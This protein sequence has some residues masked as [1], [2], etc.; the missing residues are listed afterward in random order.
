MK[1][2]SLARPLG[3]LLALAL[4]AGVWGCQTWVPSSD[5]PSGKYLDHPPQNLS[6]LPPLP[7]PRE[8]AKLEQA[9]EKLGP[10]V[11]ESDEGPVR[12]VATVRAQE[13]RPTTLTVV[14]VLNEDV[15]VFRISDKGELTFVAKLAH[16]D[17]MD[18]DSEREWR[19]VAV[20]LKAG[21]P[22]H[23]KYTVKEASATWLLR[24]PPA[25]RPV[26]RPQVG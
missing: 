2:R 18:L 16:G 3:V 6:S 11:E 1:R 7:V 22:Y 10:P 25:T 13:D 17:V 12:I 19:Y 8:L 5:L 20:F 14:N 23:F 21:S 4:V 24:I 26:H 9:A 15:V